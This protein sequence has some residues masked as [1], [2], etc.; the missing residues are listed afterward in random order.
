[1]TSYTYDGWKCTEPAGPTD[2]FE[3]G[4]PH[5]SPWEATR[6]FRDRHGFTLD[7]EQWPQADEQDDISF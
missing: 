6:R 7:S 3:T 5:V 1:M 4:E 2:L